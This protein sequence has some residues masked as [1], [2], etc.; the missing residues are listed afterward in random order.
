MRFRGILIAN[1]GEV[2]IRISRACADLG[3]PS[4]AIFSEDDK[5]SLHVKMADDAVSISGVGTSS[6]LDIDALLQVAKDT[7]CDAIHPGYGFLSERAD[8]AEQCNEQS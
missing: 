5:N 1:R 8:F 7:G 6:Y 4:V 3:V 2:A